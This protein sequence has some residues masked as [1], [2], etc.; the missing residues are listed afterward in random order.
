MKDSSA[1]PKEVVCTELDSFFRHNPNQVSTEAAVHSGCTARTH[2]L[3]VW[4][5]LTEHVRLWYRDGP[6]EISC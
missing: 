2:L 4:F 1:A 5:Y 3:H 6:A